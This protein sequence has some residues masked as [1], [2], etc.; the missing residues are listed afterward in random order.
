MKIY[1]QILKKSWA[2]NLILMTLPATAALIL[3]AVNH[4]QWTGFETRYI[5]P[6]YVCM[7]AILAL[8]VLADRQFKKK[9]KQIQK[10]E[11]ADKLS[12]YKTAYSKKLQCYD[13]IGVLVLVMVAFIHQITPM[14][15]YLLALLLV[16]TNRPTEIK[17][18]YE[19]SLS[20]EETEKFKYLKFS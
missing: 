17:L 9:I 14:V 5:Y 20:K 18:K 7:L 11:L 3:W 2:V 8:V 12:E 6:T 1:L 15:F 13:I 10:K 16:I 4:R 19:L